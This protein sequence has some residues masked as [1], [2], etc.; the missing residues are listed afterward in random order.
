VE[1]RQDKLKG[2]TKFEGKIIEGP[3]DDKARRKWAKEQDLMK[4]K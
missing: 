4:F 3:N 1:S 2:R